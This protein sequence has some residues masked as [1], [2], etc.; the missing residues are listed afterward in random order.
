MARSVHQI[1]R[2]L[3][4]FVQIVD[5]KGD[6]RHNFDDLGHVAMQLEPDPF[7]PVGTG[8]KTGDVNPEVRDMMLMSRGCVCGIQMR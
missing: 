7:D 2:P 5:G 8:L 3:R 1:S 6:V 4:R